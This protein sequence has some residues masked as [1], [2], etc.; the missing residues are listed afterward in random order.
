MEGATGI[1]LVERRMQS[2]KERKWVDV[3]E[4]R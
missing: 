2:R 3:L 1:Q 4:L